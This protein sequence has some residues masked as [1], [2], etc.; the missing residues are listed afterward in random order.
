M[1]GETR[2]LLDCWDFHAQSV[3][4]AWSLLEWIVWDLFEFE[5]A[6]RVL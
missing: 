5:K 2:I 1:N 6:S 4:E 3:N